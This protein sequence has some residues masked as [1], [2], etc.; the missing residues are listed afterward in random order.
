M[1]DFYYKNQNGVVTLHCRAL[2]EIKGIRH[3]FTTRE[4]GVSTEHLRSMNLSFSREERATVE[5]NYRRLCQAEGFCMPRMT[6]TDQTHTA[7]VRLVDEATAGMGMSKASDV[8]DTDGLITVLTDTPLAVFVA[9]CA[10]VLMYDRGSGAVAAVHSGWRGTRAGIAARALEQMAAAFGTKMQNVIAA[11]GPCIGK[12]CYEVGAD[13][14]EQ[15]TRPEDRSLFEPRDGGKY[16]FDLKE[17][18][19]RVLEQAGVR[20]IYVTSEC[21]CC[22]PEL[23]F[24]HRASKGLR[25]NM[26]GIIQITKGEDR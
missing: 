16:H 2:D 5:E 19:R 3:C 9:D 1:S 24:S 6:L 21:T 14:K 20:E 26:A 7:T 10:P 11:V 12:C 22:K 8:R 15:W 25:G 4:G 13:F 18:N 17:A 23:L